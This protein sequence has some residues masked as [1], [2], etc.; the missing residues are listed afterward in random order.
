[1]GCSTF[2]EVYRRHGRQTQLPGPI[3]A[4]YRPRQL[5][6][7]S[8]IVMSSFVPT[9]LIIYIENGEI[10]TRIEPQPTSG[11]KTS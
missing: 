2:T 11:R 5:A 4:Y 9:T 6:R 10:K 8:R 1:V 3:R 7:T